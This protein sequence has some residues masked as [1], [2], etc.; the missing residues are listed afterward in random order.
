VKWLL[1]GLLLAAGVLAAHKLSLDREAH[2]RADAILWPAY[3]SVSNDWALNHGQV[4]DPSHLERV[5]AQDKK[6][7]D[8]MCKAFEAWHDAMKQA[9]Y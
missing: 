4:S 2:Q 7:F 1:V 8:A 9:G 6:R 3:V 5:D